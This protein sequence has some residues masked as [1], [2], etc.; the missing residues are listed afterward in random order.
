MNGKLSMTIADCLW[1]WLLR[2][3]YVYEGVM[4]TGRLTMVL[5]GVG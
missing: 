5:L 2:N 1:Q 4:V 3:V